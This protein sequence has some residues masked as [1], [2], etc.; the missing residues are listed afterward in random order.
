MSDK[1][2]TVTIEGAPRTGTGKTFTRK[3]RQAGKIPAILNTK[4]QST[5]L[6]LD[7]K[8]LPKA[9]KEGGRQFNL[10]V[11]GQSQRVAITELQIH[12]V[13]RWALH[14]DLAPVG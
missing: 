3:L 5:L 14:V 1:Q 13:R 4:G 9:W 2:V 11:G 7:P 6:E 8:L 10:V 12:P